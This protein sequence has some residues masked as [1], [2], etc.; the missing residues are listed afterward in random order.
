L[1]GF[2]RQFWRTLSVQGSNGKY[3]HSPL[4]SIF[5][6]LPRLIWTSGE[7]DLADIGINA[8]NLHFEEVHSDA[9]R[10]GFGESLVLRSIER[11]GSF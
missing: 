6:W 5:I 2:Y 10:I 3:P 11:L 7:S 8:F 1:Q 9:I 4:L